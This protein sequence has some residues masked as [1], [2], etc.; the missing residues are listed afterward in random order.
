MRE[1]LTDIGIRLLLFMCRPWFWFLGQIRSQGE[2]DPDLD[3]ERWWE[4]DD[5]PPLAYKVIFGDDYAAFA[6]L[7]EA[8]KHV[9]EYEE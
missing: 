9:K 6:T 2:V 7:K 5:G 3:D 1:R 8:Q 4:K